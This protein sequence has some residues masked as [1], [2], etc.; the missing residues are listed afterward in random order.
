MNQETHKHLIACIHLGLNRLRMALIC[1]LGCGSMYADADNAMPT[2]KL[3]RAAIQT[4]EE[5]RAHL[6]AI[7]RPFERLLIEFSEKRTDLDLLDPSKMRESE[8]SFVIDGRNFYLSES[9][10]DQRARE[11]RFRREISFDG[12]NIFVGGSPLGDKGKPNLTKY[13]AASGSDPDRWTFRISI[14]YVYAAGW[15]FPEDFHQIRQFQRSTSVV[16]DFLDTAT[17]S[18]VEKYEGGIRLHLLIP[19]LLVARV[20]DIDMSAYEKELRRRTKS[21][22][23]QDRQLKAI[24]RIRELDAVRRVVFDLSAEMNYQPVKREDF[25]SRGELW[26]RVVVEDWTTLM[27]GVVSLPKV[28]TVSNFI[29]P[30]NRFVNTPFSESHL[31]F[32]AVRRVPDDY[33]FDLNRGIYRQP[34]SSIRDRA[35]FEASTRPGHEVR[36]VISADGKMLETLTADIQRDLQSQKHERIW[37]VGAGCALICVLVGVWAFRSIP[38]QHVAHSREDKDKPKNA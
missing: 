27:D 30:D 12:S 1:V 11:S 7:R 24:N 35:V 34:G 16:Q 20:K 9:Y 5:L 21:I 33:Q 31:S 28:A 15:T 38:K 2:P 22:E 19:D 14:P 25:N 4:V 8:W 37:F 32:K 3:P 13:S 10:N 17:Q 29:T 26:M 18:R 23:F 36:Y 6:G